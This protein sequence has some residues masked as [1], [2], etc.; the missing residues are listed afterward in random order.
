MGDLVCV[1]SL[2]VKYPDTGKPTI[3]PASYP[4]L[5]SGGR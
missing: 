4:F 5:R 2:N 1:K 3:P